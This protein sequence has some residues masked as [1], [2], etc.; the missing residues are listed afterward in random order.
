M[1]RLLSPAA[2]AA[3]ATIAIMLGGSALAYFTSQGLGTASAAV[4]K[5]NTPA[6]S[7]ATAAAGGTVTVTW[8][9]VTAPGAGAV[10]YYLTRDGEEPA[11]TCP[12][13]AGP[14]TVTTCKDA[15]LPLGKHEYTVTA[16]WQTW[17]ATSAVESVTIKIGEATKFT[18][19]GS[20]S[21]I[22]AGGSVNLTIAAKDENDNTVTT[23]TGSHSL[24]F[25]GA[26]PSPGG[27][28]PTVADSGGTAVA[29][30][31]PTTLTFTSGVA[32]VKSKKNGALKLYR[33]DSA[34]V[35]ASEGS[36][37]TPDPLAVTVSH[38]TASRF[39]LEA[40]AAATAAGAADDLTIIAQDV[41]G[42]TATS[43]SG[44]KKLTFSG[45]SSSP[46]GNVPAVID[47]GD[48]EVAFGSATSIRFSAGVAGAAPGDGGTMLLYKSG[49]T[50]V[51]ATASGM[52]T[53]TPATVTVAPGDAAKFALAASTT[54]PVAAATF[55]FTTTAQ[56]LYG[57]TA[58]SYAGSKNI[59]FSGAE[60]SPSGALPTVVNSAGTAINFGSATA[61]TFTAGVAAVGS[62]KNGVG[63]LNKAGAASVTATDGTISNPSPLA[64]TVATGTA[65][66][67]SF[68]SLTATAGSIG[69][70]CL[71][72]CTITGLTNAGKISANITITDSVGN[73][74]S[75][76]GS[77]KTV[78][79]TATSGST[80]TGSPLTL[81]ASGVAT[82]NTQFTYKPPANGNFSHT[83]TAA[84]S[85]YTSATA[86]ASR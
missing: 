7:A 80:I 23:Y 81:P 84:S 85:G 22:K 69:S 51:S 66:K 20:A 6:I 42:N 57:N 43:Y 76:L 29:F 27:D 21:S 4:G 82:T 8:G 65:S 17:S 28:D 1:R 26:E 70:P 71:F 73:P 58:T 83:I 53:L 78:T 39:V 56:D 31:S 10:K 11:G 68:S 32:T 34:A 86:T 37:T 15:E 19:S 52:T 62:S 46:E 30:G 79:I 12:T 54:T 75:N 59:T 40:A 50:T 61:L 14:T 74:S 13:E 60:A 48:D 41:Y 38:A 2:A 63:K 16:V 33:A 5:L 77:A 64:F 72:T 9:A 35:V 24:V 45:A 36:L 55:N 3:I 49:S 44:F 47:A 67:V 18:I 25:S